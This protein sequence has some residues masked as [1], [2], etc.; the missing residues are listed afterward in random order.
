MDTSHKMELGLSMV[1]YSGLHPITLKMYKKF[2]HSDNNLISTESTFV[3]R[4]LSEVLSLPKITSTNRSPSLHIQSEQIKACPLLKN[5]RDN[6]VIEDLVK[7][8]S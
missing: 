6:E 2:V 1:T 8:Y 7:Y 5:E 4:N 3:P